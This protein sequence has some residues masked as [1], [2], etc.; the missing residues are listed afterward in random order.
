MTIEELI[1]ELQHMI[2][3]NP[4]IAYFDVGYFEYPRDAPLHTMYGNGYDIVN[5]IEIHSDDQLVIFV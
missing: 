1:I 5:E 3:V 4:K 2:E